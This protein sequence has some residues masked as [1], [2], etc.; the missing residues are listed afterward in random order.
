MYCFIQLPSFRKAQ[1][2]VFEL[3]RNGRC[4]YYR[5]LSR[6]HPASYPLVTVCWVCYRNEFVLVHENL[7]CTCNSLI[8][9]L[10]IRVLAQALPL[11]CLRNSPLDKPQSL[12]DL[13]FNTCFYDHRCCRKRLPFEQLQESTKHSITNQYV[14]RQ[15]RLSARKHFRC[16]LS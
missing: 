13:A 14:C 11:L 1:S 5:F 8:D 6:S 3:R 15:T 2:R 9:S 16:S 10:E 12:V 4:F 7:C